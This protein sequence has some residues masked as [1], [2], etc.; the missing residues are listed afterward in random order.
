V[1]AV[2][3]TSEEI[4]QKACSL[5]EVEYEPL[6]GVFDAEYGASDKAPLIHPDLGNYECVNFIFP[7]AGTN[8]S[9]HFKIRKGNVEA[10]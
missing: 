3:A 1:A 6:E 8:I 10:A 7:K 5:I 4:A 2:A 9:N